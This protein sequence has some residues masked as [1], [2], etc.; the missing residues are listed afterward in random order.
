MNYNEIS[1]FVDIRY[2]ITYVNSKTEI[3]FKNSKPIFGYFDKQNQEQRKLNQWSFIVVPQENNSKRVTI[4]NGDDI[5]SI[6]LLIIDT[7]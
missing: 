2:L 6:H 3:R 4:I 7:I 5:E 1:E